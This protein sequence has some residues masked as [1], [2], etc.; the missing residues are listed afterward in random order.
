MSAKQ[1]VWLFF[2][3]SGRISRAVYLLT[4]ALTMVILMFL[5]YRA[6]MEHG[7][8][9]GSG[10][11]NVAFSIAVIASL[12]TQAALG[13]KRIQDIGKSG[14]FAVLLFVPLINIVVFFVLCLYPGDAGANTYGR[15]TDSPN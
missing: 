4:A 13:A 6:S 12:W 1:L 9:T 8:G 11:W 14:L 2:G 7:G 10:L 15:T 5:F 3:F